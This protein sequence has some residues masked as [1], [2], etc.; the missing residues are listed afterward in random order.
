MVKINIS[1]PKTGKTYQKEV[2]T[3][4]LV[5]LKIG[6][7]FDGGKIGLKGYK[8]QITGGTDSDGF[9][10]RPDIEGTVRKRLLLAGPPGHHPK[11]KGERRRKSVRGNTV[12]ED[13]ALINVKIVKHGKR[14]LDRLLGGEKQSK[15]K[16]K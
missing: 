16:K 13:I 9:P 12:S 5:G 6:E 14:P 1:N 11:E 4:G 15:K 7:E 8:L 10:M 2:E 3:R